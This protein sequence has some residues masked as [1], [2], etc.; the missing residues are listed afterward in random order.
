LGLVLDGVMVKE[1][2]KEKTKDWEQEYKKLVVFHNMSIGKLEDD[3]FNLQALCKNT[4]IK[5]DR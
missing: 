3:L 5:N 2:K 1:E 4:R